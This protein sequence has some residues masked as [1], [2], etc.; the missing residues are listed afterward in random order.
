MVQKSQFF[1]FT[2]LIAFVL[3]IACGAKREF[4]SSGGVNNN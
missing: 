3:T 1:A 4:V 2:L